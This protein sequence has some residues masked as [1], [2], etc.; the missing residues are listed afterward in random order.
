MKKLTTILV[1]VALFSTVAWAATDLDDL[2]DSLLAQLE[3]ATYGIIREGALVDRLWD[4]EVDLKGQG[5]KGATL[6]RL[7]QLR[8]LV[9]GPGAE[10]LT[11]K[12][13]ILEWH[14]LKKQSTAPIIRRLTALEAAFLGQTRIGEGSIVERVNMLMLA[15]FDRQTPQTMQ[16]ILKRWT[17]V[18][19]ELLTTLDSGKLTKGA[20]FRYRVVE[21]VIS[22]GKLLIPA[23]AIG[24]G[25]LVKVSVA[26]YFGKPG[27]FEA[28][29]GTLSA[30]DGSR[31][32][33][34]PRKTLWQ[35][36]E[37]PLRLAAGLSMGGLLISGQLW[38]GALGLL[39]RGNQLVI[40]QGTE[41]ELEVAQPCEV[42]AL[43]LQ[44]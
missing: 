10:S 18:K 6:T 14:V 42:T 19:V 34:V 12:L 11:Y 7:F 16:V 5:Q 40:P 28:D 41:L 32:P 25:Q 21:D 24:E 37:D 35:K 9:F 4:L 43:V 44:K 2:S 36:D 20:P 30:I 13:S 31:I 29:F 3:E 27:F 8:D 1:C 39:V 23:G 26:G 38:G 17:P 22:S 33:V 15:S